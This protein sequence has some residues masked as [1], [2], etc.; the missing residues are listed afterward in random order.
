LV[1]RFSGCWDSLSSPARGVTLDA[2]TGTDPPE[3]HEALSALL[4]RGYFAFHAEMA[5]L[6]QT[7]TEDSRPLGAD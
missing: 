7:A 3:F 2:C 5:P 4:Q 6:Q 1:L